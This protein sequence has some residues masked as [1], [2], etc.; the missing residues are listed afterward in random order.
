MKI[1]SLAFVGSF[2]YRQGL[3]RPLGPEFVFIGRSNVGKST[4]INALVG[5]KDLA[6][7]SNAPGRTRSANF[8]SVNDQFCFVDVPGYGYAKVSRLERRHW[9]K[10][11][12]GYLKER[13]AL[14]GVVHLFDIR[15]TPTAEDRETAE[16]VRG[17]GKGVC[18]V[19][20]KIDKIKPAAV[21]RQIAEHLA[22][23]PVAETSAAI[24]FSS[25]SGR[26]RRATWVW[27]EDVLSL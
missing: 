9:Q 1:K 21:D 14:A 8:Y 16:L 15:H 11:I 6:H 7:T 10:L 13:K 26:G 25:Q 20:T 4:F 23:L 5:R 17:L 12:V 3:P 22:T 19:F 2:G 18:I 27:I 24:A